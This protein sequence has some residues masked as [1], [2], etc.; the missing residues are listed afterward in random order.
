MKKIQKN[1][2][3]SDDAN[4][5]GYHAAGKLLTERF[6]SE[7][8]MKINEKFRFVSSDVHFHLLYKHYLTK[9]KRSE[10]K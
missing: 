2:F 8:K 9:E 7:K 6:K 1:V 3:R 4:E 5:T 10:K